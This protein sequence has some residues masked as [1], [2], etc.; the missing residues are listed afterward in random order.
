MGPLIK[1]IERAAVA[2]HILMN[3]HLDEDQRIALSKHNPIWNPEDDDQFSVMQSLYCRLLNIE[4]AVDQAITLL[5][6]DNDM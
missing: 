2:R 6:T 3:I 4:S 1:K 5:E